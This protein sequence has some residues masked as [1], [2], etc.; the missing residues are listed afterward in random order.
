[1]GSEMREARRM[2]DGTDA[3]RIYR[4]LHGLLAVPLLAFALHAQVAIAEVLDDV[5]VE[6]HDD[7]ATIRL[8]LTG[9]VH[10]VR[11]APAEAGEIVVVYLE[12]L[13]PESFVVSVV[14]EVKRSPKGAPVPQFTV[15]ARVGQA[16]SPAANPVC[17]TIQFRHPVRY[18]VRLGE[19]RRSVV[20]E[21]PLADDRH[22]PAAPAGGSP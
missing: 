14:D 15:R 17:L 21:L 9:P 1:M 19:D 13:A 7:T 10:Y 20:L 2:N 4:F 6:R 3:A 5:A 12:A 8:R 11:H 22:V 18:R 16:C